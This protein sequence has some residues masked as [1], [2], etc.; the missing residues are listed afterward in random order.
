[1]PFWVRRLYV[2]FDPRF[3]KPSYCSRWL[4]AGMVADM[5]NG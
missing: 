1:M 5:W 2:F 4:G 3:K